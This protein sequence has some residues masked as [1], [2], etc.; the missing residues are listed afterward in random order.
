MDF[1]LDE[2]SQ[3]LADLTGQILADRVDHQRSKQL[4]FGSEP[5]FDRELWSALADAGV[6]SATLPEDNNGSG[7]GAVALGAILEVAGRF[8][9]PV[10]LMETL[11]MAAQILAKYGTTP[12][13]DRWLTPLGEGTSILVS[14]LQED[15]ADP[16]R[17]STTATSTG[18]TYVLNGHKICVPAGQIADGF[19]VSAW[20]DDAPAL[21]VIPADN[22]G[23]ERVPLI[24]TGRWPDAD[25]TLT[26]VAVPP[27]ARVGTQADP[28]QLI[29]DAVDL[30]VVSQ[31]AFGMGVMSEALSLTSSYTK[32]RKQFDQPIAS[33]QA[34]AHRAA[35]AYVDTESITLT[36]KHALWRIAEGL[37]A[38]RH[39]AVAKYYLA[40]A[41]QRVV[42]AAQ[43]LHGGIGVDRD[44]PLHRYFF[45]AKQ[46]EL[47]LGGTTESLARIGRLLATT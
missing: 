23:V 22:P 30:A 8:V 40:E 19:I 3:A 41:G 39:V 11:G 1:T 34:V 5:R 7:L 38:R 6:L 33:F 44:Y 45:A 37:P 35:D 13:R 46:L 42:H 28:T 32:T 18:G 36:T 15:L 10:P 17:P 2:S 16:E 4:E 21:F 27:D 14:A 25:V 47:Y 26:D 43:H 9:A 31:C 20:L 29:G 24:T 12:Q